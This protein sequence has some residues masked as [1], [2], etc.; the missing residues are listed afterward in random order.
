[1]TYHS[2]ASDRVKDYRVEPYRVVYGFGTLYLRAW[3]AKYGEMRT[4]AVGRIRKLTVLE[5]TFT[6]SHDDGDETFSQS[7]GIY[8]G[9]PADIELE[10]DRH[11]ARYVAE[12]EWHPS[13]ALQELPDGRV[14]VTMRVCEDWALRTWILGFGGHVRVIKPKALAGV[15]FDEI[16]RAG[17]QY[18]QRLVFDEVEADESDSKQRVLSFTPRRAGGRAS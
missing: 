1:M 15:I 8:D 5:D 12:R 11:V 7:L 14:R 2:Y 16:T 10:F 13:Q 6:P 17:D 4:F 18:A 9:T 3:V